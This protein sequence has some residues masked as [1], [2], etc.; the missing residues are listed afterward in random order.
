MEGGSNL[1]RNKGRIITN[2]IRAFVVISICV[3]F[4]FPLLYTISVAFMSPETVNDPGVLLIPRKFSLKSIKIV[5]KVLGLGSAMRQTL[6]VTIFSTLGTAFSCSLAGYSLARYK[7]SEKNLMFFIVLIMIIVPSQTL[8]TAQFL[9]YRFFTFGGLLTLISPLTKIKSVSLIDTLWVYILPSFFA[10]GL[11]AGIF[12]FIFRQFFLSV[13]IN[14]EEAAYMDGC[15]AWKTFFKVIIPMSIPV[16]VTVILFSVV[17]HWTDYYNSMAYFTEQKVLLGQAM[18]DI[19]TLLQRAGYL[20][21]GGYNYFDARTF[22]QAVILIAI[23]PLVSMYIV[24]Q[25]QFTESIER[26]GLV[27]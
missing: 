17:W 23:S 9:N 2:C 1:Y 12:I 7:Y 24:L 5:W 13:P 4:I 3:L 22:R 25:H 21:S 6:I 27:G 19:G 15:G 14:L 16:Y 18:N 8:Q 26:T 10:Q 20:S 11:K